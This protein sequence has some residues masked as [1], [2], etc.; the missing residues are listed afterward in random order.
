M[1]NKLPS[2][3]ARLDN[4]RVVVVIAN[5]DED[6]EKSPRYYEVLIPY[7][8]TERLQR[9]KPVLHYRLRVRAERIRG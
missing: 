3:F 7:S 4:G 8:P 6:G 1:K 2:G 5:T 9:R